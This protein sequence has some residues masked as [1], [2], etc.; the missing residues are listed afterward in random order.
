V[1]LEL[2]RRLPWLLVFRAAVATSLLALTLIADLR[3]VP[4]SHISPLLYGVIIGTYAVVMTLGLLLRARASAIAVAAAYLALAAMSAAIV[5]Q[6]TG[7]FDSEFTFLYLLAV[8]DGA[9]I[10]ARQVALVMA[11]ASSLAFGS[12]L[13]LQL[14]G[15]LPPAFNNPTDWGFT[16]AAIVH[17]AG[18][19]LAAVLAGYLA[20][21]LRH[22]KE[23]ASA[24]EGHLRRAHELH[25]A[26]LESLPL[27]VVTVEGDRV[28]T[29]N[30][31]AATIFGVPGEALV[32]RPLPAALA[33]P[34][35]S[36]VRLVD[37]DV[38][39]DGRRRS[40]TI[41]RALLLDGRTPGRPAAATAGARE[42]LVFEDRT[43]VVAL[44]RKL[45][46]QD[47]LAMLGGLA[48][49]IAHEIRN[50][51]AAISGSLELLAQG[52]DA[53]SSKPLCDIAGRELERLNHLVED[54]LLY[55]R[56]APLERA[57]VDVAALGRE[58]CV[59]LAADASTAEH[60]VH[61]TSPDS[62]VASVDPYQLRQV[63]W[64]LVR[65]AFDASP[66][67]AAVDISMAEERRGAGGVA[68]AIE[69]SD[70]GPGIDPAMKD[71]LFQPFQT[72]KPKGTGLGLAVVRRIVESHGGS[73]ELTSRAEQGTVARVVLPA[74][75]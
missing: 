23:E 48:A 61:Y 54:F 28:L 6:A 1:E 8:L 41:S 63:L 47:R 52:L 46:E 66:A 55:A 72:T 31:G 49:A 58:L 21:L 38:E 74:S 25:A 12:Q 68:L 40:L 36:G 7:V 51:L 29:A 39:I 19:Y 4:V 67:G 17:V 42:V 15:V 56:P 18:F 32:G 9:I 24:A 65:N 27:G 53:A 35:A 64:N 75:S 37:A 60:P 34:L 13:A 20:E 73:V 30:G 69:V 14:H 26:I 11:T 44:E 43:D 33:R 62:L 2:R 22:A 50:P 3:Q 70:R 59:V 57:D 10:G 45:Q 16:V 5:V 71:R